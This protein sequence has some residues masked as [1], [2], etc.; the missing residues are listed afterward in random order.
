MSD[1]IS[2]EVY[3]EG[4][5]SSPRSPDFPPDQ[6]I[7]PRNIP[8]EKQSTVQQIMTGKRQAFQSHVKVTGETIGGSPPHA[9][10]LRSAVSSHSKEPHSPGRHL[11]LSTLLSIHFF[12]FSTSIVLTVERSESLTENSSDWRDP[13]LASLTDQQLL[14]VMTS[15]VNLGVD[16]SPLC[17]AL[18]LFYVIPFSLS[19]SIF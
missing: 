9:V 1:V 8:L 3:S 17:K 10:W 18:S 6:F 2:V 15:F 12:S 7:P 19:C 4:P 11:L 14:E 5:S 16:L 13:R